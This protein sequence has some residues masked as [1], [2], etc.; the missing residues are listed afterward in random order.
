MKPLILIADADPLNLETCT[1]I[2]S[3]TYADRFQVRCASQLASTHK[4][5]E[6][7]HQQSI[8]LALI[9]IDQDLL[10]DE[11]QDFFET[12]RSQ[13]PTSRRVLST[14]SLP[15]SS[16]FIPDEDFLIHYLLQKPWHP[17]EEKLL[18]VMD[19]LLE[20]W[21]ATCNP[22]QCEL[23]I[24]GLR[25]SAE[26][27]EIK[28]FLARNL[29]PYEYLDIEENSS[30]QSIMQQ[31][32]L[33]RHNIPCVLLPNGKVLTN[34]TKL[35]LARKV[36]LSTRAQKPFYDLAI[37][38]GGPGGLSAAV[39]ASSEGLRTV[40]IERQAPGGQA[41]T[42][43]RIENYLGFPSGLSG[44]DL[45]RRAVVQARRFG[46]EILTPQEAVDLKVNGPYRIITLSDGSEIVCH[47]VVLSMGLTYREPAIQR[48]REM[49]GAGVYYGATFTETHTCRDLPVFV[50]GAGNSAG[51]SALYLANYSSQ[52][53]LV[54]RGESLEAKM[55]QYLV[56]RIQ[57]HPKINV[58]LK[59]EVINV[60][61]SKHL[62]SVTIQ[63]NSNHTEAVCNA[64][65]LFIFIGAQ[66]A[67]SWL[68]GTLLLD[69]EGFILTGPA[70]NRDNQMPAS[71]TVDRQP[72]LMES[73]IPGV[74]AVGDVRS[75]SVKRVASAVGEGS[76]AVQFIHQYLNKLR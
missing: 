66:P 14:S 72:Y 3:K 67:T 26:T 43:S 31:F 2:L 44:A 34:P 23:K 24:L 68:N 33:E 1:G 13:F 56:D 53:T 60:F 4:I 28:D 48:A 27:H 5:L 76:I 61:G 62:E 57:N 18:P 70:V 17:I 41:G 52:V 46:V 54:V 6:Q 39:Y 29:V 45:A 38:G 50:V 74:F 36:G 22:Q 49:V 71:W 30:A 19:D 32:G 55:S 51:Q 25:W 37:I 21:L 8:P 69:E 9:I 11:Q 75:D 35:E 16:S 12:T 65:A 63:D 40:M 10:G 64:A 7:I 58:R 47:T 42:S 73:S 15:N 20:D 59:S